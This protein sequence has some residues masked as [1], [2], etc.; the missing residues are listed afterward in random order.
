MEKMLLYSPLAGP[1]LRYIASHLVTEILG[2]DLQIVSSVRDIAGTERP[3]INYSAAHFPAGVNII[4]CGLLDEKGITGKPVRAG[5]HNGLPVLF[6]TAG[7]DDTGFDILAASFF[8]L[9]RYEEYLPFKKDR[10]GR[11]PLAE[12]IAYRNGFHMEP[13]VEQWAGE[14]KKAILRKFPAVVFPARE[15]RYIPTIDIDIPWAY[16]DRSLLR[17]SGGFARALL[18]GDINDIVSRY[19]VLAGGDQDPYDTFSHIFRLHDEAGLKPL[20]FLSAGTYSRYDKCVPLNSPQ[21]RKLVREISLRY[22]TGIHP[23]YYSAIDGELMGKEIKIL[24]HATE[25]PVSGSRQHYLRLRM[26]E[27]YRLLDD[28]GITDDYT[29]GWAEAPGFRACTCTPFLF[30]DL[31]R[32]RSTNLRIW[33]FQIM[34]GSFTDYMHT[35]PLQSESLA[36]NII[37]KIGE[38]GGTLITLWHNESFCGKGRWKNREN[39]YLNIIKEAALWVKK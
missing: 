13:L 18:K 4:P 8:M 19:R 11:F 38:A 31:M 9:S 22:H 33:P 14:L 28:N 5:R 2:L 36:L 39:L 25:R 21:Y 7:V 24:S 30:Y 27:T 6:R 23:S 20:F 10:H 17:T 12:S 26:P 16:K 32:E 34:D 35:D 37:R 1:R 29:M 15:F 3:F